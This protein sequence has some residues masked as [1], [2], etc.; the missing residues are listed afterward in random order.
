MVETY[1]VRGI[2]WCTFRV[3]DVKMFAWREFTGLRY[4]LDCGVVSF[5]VFVL[6]RDGGTYWVRNARCTHGFEGA[7]DS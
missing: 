5:E 4:A 1:K 3:E 2:T 6:E 7:S